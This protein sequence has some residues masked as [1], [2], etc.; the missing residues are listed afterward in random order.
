VRLV[1]DLLSLSTESVTD[2]VIAAGAMRG[3]RELLLDQ[4]A[5]ALVRRDAA[6]A[7]SN[8]AAGTVSQAQHLLD[9]TGAVDGLFQAWEA[10]PAQSIRRECAWAV[11]NAAK[12]G[13]P[14]LE[15]LGSQRLLRLVALAVRGEQDPLLQRALL[16]A[17]E[18]VLKHGEEQASL[19]GLAQNP[20]VAAAETCGL[21]ESLQ[22]LNHVETE[23]I[24]YKAASIRER[25][26]SGPG[27]DRENEPP[28]QSTPR[29]ERPDQSVSAHTPSA[30]C[31]GSPLRPAAYKFG[32]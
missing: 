31:G 22:A 2:A 32:A 19:K 10:A 30:I 25:W 17:G 7:L 13:A 3:L 18:A 28:A 20:L 6:W 5:P 16:D 11:A 21:V 9:A 26:F 1:G 23:G 29:K 27:G 8:V 4:H 15:C 14:F 24:R 12:R